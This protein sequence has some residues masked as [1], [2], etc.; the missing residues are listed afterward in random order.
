MWAGAGEY[1]GIMRACL[2]LA[3]MDPDTDVTLTTQLPP[4]GGAEHR[5]AQDSMDALCRTNTDLCRTNTD[6]CT[7]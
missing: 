4:H 7:D 6:E 1:I 2:G 5:C 3:V